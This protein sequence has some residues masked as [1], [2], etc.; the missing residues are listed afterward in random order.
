M[1][2][3]ADDARVSELQQRLADLQKTTLA[4]RKRLRDLLEE[5]GACPARDTDL[6]AEV[7]ALSRRCAA[8]E[9]DNR[10]L[11]ALAQRPTPVSREHG[12]AASAV[13]GPLRRALAPFTRKRGP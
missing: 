8:L 7:E 11:Q 6:R 13:L 9:R 1:T 4:D 2:D 3:D 12:G 10:H 5:R